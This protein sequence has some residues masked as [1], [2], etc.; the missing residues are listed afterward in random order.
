MKQP[1]QWQG[2]RVLRLSW[3]KGREFDPM[4]LP[5]CIFVLYFWFCDFLK[6]VSHIFY[7]RHIVNTIGTWPGGKP[8]HL[9]VQG[10]GFKPWWKQNL[11]F[12]SLVFNFFSQLQTLISHSKINLFDSNFF[13]L[14]I[15]LTYFDIV[16]KNSKKG[17]IWYNFIRLK[18]G[19]F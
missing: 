15:Y 12:L 11:Y 8:F 5:F 14:L 7:Q 6:H 18:S 13:T 17:F 16:Q 19:T 3:P 10:C 1:P 4:G 2:M 9:W